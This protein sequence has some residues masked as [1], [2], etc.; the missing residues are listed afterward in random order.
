MLP[1]P[2]SFYTHTTT[3]VNRSLYSFLIPSSQQ[4]RFLILFTL[5]TGIGLVVG[6]S[7]NEILFAA[8]A[9]ISRYVPKQGLDLIFLTSLIVG[10]TLGVAQWLILRK[11][12]P[13]WQWIVAT[14]VGWSISSVFAKAWHNQIGG[15]LNSIFYIW[16]GITGWLLLRHNVFAARWWLFVAP[17]SVY[18]FKLTSAIVFFALMQFNLDVSHLPFSVVLTQKI[19]GAVP[20]G[21]I[22]ALALCTFHKKTEKNYAF[23]SQLDSPLFLATEITDKSQIQVLSQRL[24]DKIKRAWQKKYNLT[25]DL[26]YIVAIA[27]DGSIIFCHPVNQPAINNINLTPLPYLVQ[28]QYSSKVELQQ[29]VARFRVVFTPNGDL[30]IRY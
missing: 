28:S 20:L 16:L 6:I 5:M 14:C 13:G 25:Q 7:I 1:S 27:A 26:I 21:L 11:Y 4:S 9:P 15:S 22:Q 12:I 2:N 18:V 17:F 24:K 19:F 30:E 8:I 10:A 23:I 3:S 29:S